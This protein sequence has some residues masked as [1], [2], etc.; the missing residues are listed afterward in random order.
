MA[1][2]TIKDLPTH[3]TL[4]RK[5]MSFVR[6]GGAPWVFG[7]IRPFVAA[8]PSVGPIVNF[9]QTNNIFVADQMNNQFQ[10]IDITNSAANASISVA[11]NQ[12]GLNFK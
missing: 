2:L 1:A 12:G 9:Y 10:S 11:A 3:R 6:G 7:W 4:E 8:V 5:K